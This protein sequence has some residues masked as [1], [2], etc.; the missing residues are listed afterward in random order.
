MG[1][2]KWLGAGGGWP[3]STCGRPISGG[4]GEP[5]LCGETTAGVARRC[6]VFTSSTSPQRRRLFPSE[7]V[8]PPAWAGFLFG[9]R[10][11]RR[12][13]W[14]PPPRNPSLRAPVPLRG[15]QVGPSPRG[16]GPAFA[17]FC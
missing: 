9:A 14:L 1:A 5:P 4:T 11:S 13:P 7:P 15:Q 8:A 2:A 17:L 16:A 3:P 6:Q 10:C 12:R